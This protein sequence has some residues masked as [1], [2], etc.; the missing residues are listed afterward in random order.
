MN[1]RTLL[2]GLCALATERL[3]AADAPVLVFAAASL[4][5]AL[6]EVDRVFTDSRHV[7]VRESFASSAVL[8]RQ[9]ETGAPAQLFLSADEQWMDYLE[10]RQR[11]V[12]GSRRDL[13]G[14][15][16]VLIAPADSTLQL[17]VQPGM[18]LRE[19][20]GKDRLAMG[21]PAS[22][23]AGIYGKA[24][25]EKLGVW[26][27]VASQIA[28]ADSVRGA[29]ALVSRGEAP[30]GIVYRTDALIAKGVRVVSEFPPDSHPPIRY[31]AALIKGA[32]RN[33]SELLSFLS[34]STAQAL[35]ARHGFQTLP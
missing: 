27:Q 13:L 10:R 19:A 12:Q 30:L 35:F 2:L 7:P 22:V 4:T 23:P 26:S 34:S 17:T 14:N 1:R 29:L 31:P 28:A 33:A 25:L 16:L 8:A 32:T 21:E 20:L 6:Q 3:P 15:R 18:K 11:I 5:D 24:A 9:I